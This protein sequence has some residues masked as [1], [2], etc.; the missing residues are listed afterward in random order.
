MGQKKRLEANFKCSE[1]LL[2]PVTMATIKDTDNDM[3]KEN[4]W[5][6]LETCA[7]TLEILL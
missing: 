6:G 7:V 5:V 4:L 1:L 3:E 2:T